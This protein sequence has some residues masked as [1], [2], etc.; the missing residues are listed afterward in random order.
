MVVLA[1]MRSFLD[2]N[3]SISWGKEFI[4]E[5]NRDIAEKVAIMVEILVSLLDE[6]VLTIVSMGSG[7]HLL[8]GLLV[9]PSTLASGF[10]TQISW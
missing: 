8:L 7:L 1:D 9:T 2:D 5:F 6:V 3:F 10:S 4:Q